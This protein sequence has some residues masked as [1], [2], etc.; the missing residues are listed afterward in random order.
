MDTEKLTVPIFID[1]IKK[2][3]DFR[4]TRCTY[5]SVE[6]DN[7]IPDWGLNIDD[8]NIPL[9]LLGFEG[10]VTKPLGEKALF[11]SDK[12]IQ[13][14][15]ELIE[16]DDN[17]YIDVNDIWFPNFL[18]GYEVPKTSVVFRVSTKLFNLGY[19]F[20]NDKIPSQKF[21]AACGNHLPEIYFSPLENNAFAQWEQL[22]IA[23]AKEIY[24]KN[25]ALALPYSDD[26]NLN[27]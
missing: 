3:T 4:M 8:E 13:A 9:V 20:R 27:A 12:D 1:D 19:R 5:F 14:F 25:E 21:I 2:F 18:F 15:F 26:E 24:P 23:E 10:I 16:R 22:V 11:G 6:S 7:P 17:F